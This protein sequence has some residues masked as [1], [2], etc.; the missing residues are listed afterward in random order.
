MEEQQ[1]K[2]GKFVLNYGLLL[3]L[4]SVVF[5]V[6][7]YTQKM[8][9]EMSTPI[10]IVSVILTAVAI[11]M[12]VN[13]FKKANGG[14]LKIGEA[15]K[16]AVGIALISAIISLLYQ[17]VLTNFIEP[18]FIDKAMEI[19]KPKTFEQ[20]PSLTEEQWEQGVT[21]RKKMNWISYP[22]GLII[23]CVIGLVLGLITGL[24]LKKAKPAY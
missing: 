14:Y 15:L 21:M 10:M 7:L 4:V 6:M 17:Y 1:L 3:G 20:N 16:V 22:I 24:I 11:F 2:T 13:A 12:G 18:D 19:A 5:G 9:Y 8:H 23:S